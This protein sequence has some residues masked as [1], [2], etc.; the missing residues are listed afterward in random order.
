MRYAED[1]SFW[2]E[3]LK[4]DRVEYQDKLSKSIKEKADLYDKLEKLRKAKGDKKGVYVSA[5]K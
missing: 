2:R 4:I 1:E 5:L 3:R